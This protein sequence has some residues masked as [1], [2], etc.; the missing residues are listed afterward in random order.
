MKK[1]YTLLNCSTCQKILDQ[2]E[3]IDEF[4]VQNIKEQPLTLEQL[5]EIYSF[6]QSFEKIFSKR[7]Q[8][9]RKLDLKSKNLDEEGFKHYL[10]EHYTFLAR[11]VVIYEDEIFVG[12]SP[13]NVKKMLEKVNG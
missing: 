5:E 4:E 10:L 13:K 6:T 9:Y 1:I 12:N 8:L 11:P 2:I 3:N 7:A